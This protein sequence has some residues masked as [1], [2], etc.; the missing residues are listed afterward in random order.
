MALCTGYVDHAIKK[1]SCK[2]REKRVYADLT[3][4]MIFFTVDIFSP[5]STTQELKFSWEM[6]TFF[7]TRKFASSILRG[8][9][10]YQG[11]KWLY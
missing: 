2:V 4:Y 3:V 10:R 8:G 1:N 9:K 7:W 5:T 6:L 11:K